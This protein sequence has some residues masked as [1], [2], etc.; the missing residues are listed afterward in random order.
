MV[1]SRDPLPSR[2]GLADTPTAEL[3][4][5][6]VAAWDAFLTLVRHPSTDLRRQSRLP[7]WSGADACI[8]LGSW[9]QSRALPGMLASARAGGTGEPGSPD[10]GNARI[11]AAHRHES[12][13]R[14]I[15]AL[16]EARD[17]IAGFF[18]GD[19]PERLGRSMS[20]STIGP[21]PVLSLVHAAS[22]ELAVHA[23]DLRP[24]GA[25][26]PD[27]HLLDRGLA[28]LMD[29]TGALATRHRI[30]LSV[31]AQG[32]DGGWRF[33][34]G[35]DGWSTGRTPAGTFDGAGVRGT[36]TDL[37]DASAGRTGLPQLLVGRRLVAHDMTGL[38]H[39]APILTAV[40]G[41]PG[42]A[43]LRTGVAAISGVT[44]GVARL[45]GRLRR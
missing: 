7:G 1:A 36:V 23:L 28:A 38:M 13:E 34:S 37:L 43:A 19:E 33:T 14:I 44:G 29:A 2:L 4:V 11:V 26:E 20:S 5:A 30:D 27:P 16:Q 45:L 31:T 9:P 6:V 21:M 39:L 25:P 22:Y 18:A 42:G 3:G 41:L 32:P 35:P 8:H 24:C 12:V 17:D 15:A 10:E 40:P